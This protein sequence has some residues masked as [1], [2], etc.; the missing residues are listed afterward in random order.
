MSYILEQGI[1]INSHHGQHTKRKQ[2]Y[3]C[4]H[5]ANRAGHRNHKQNRISHQDQEDNC[6]HCISRLQHAAE[7]LA[8][9]GI[10]RRN[11]VNIIEFFIVQIGSP[12]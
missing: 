3:R 4:N 9:V 6:L 5:N 11:G 7:D 1:S 10:V 8:G 12:A 2:R